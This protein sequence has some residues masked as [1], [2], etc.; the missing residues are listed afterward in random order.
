MAILTTKKRK[1]LPKSKMGL[2]EVKGKGGEN[3][4]GRDA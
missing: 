3:K 1:A 4:A 2:P